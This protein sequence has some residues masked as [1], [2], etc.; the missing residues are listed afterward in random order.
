M[1]TEDHL[2]PLRDE[3]LQLIIERRNVANQLRRLHEQHLNRLREIDQRIDQLE[4]QIEHHNEH[5]HITSM[6]Q[7]ITTMILQR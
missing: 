5:G 4:H 2:S 1:T 6:W 7:R 3:R